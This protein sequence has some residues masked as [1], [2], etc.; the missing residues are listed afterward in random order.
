MISNK[1]DQVAVTLISFC[2]LNSPFKPFT[3]FPLSFVLHALERGGGG[4]VEN[5]T[6][7][8]Q[9]GS[10][11]RSKPLPFYILFLMEKVP[12][13]HTLHRKWYPFHLTS[14]LGIRFLSALVCPP[15]PGGGRGTQESF[16]RGGS[17]LRSKPLPSYKPILIE[18]LGTPFLYLPQKMVPLSYTYGATFT[19]SLRHIKACFVA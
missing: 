19:R 17:A 1:V 13:S 14:P 11:S 3:S 8:I 6:K 10:T 2:G 9:G 5:S 7:F 12:L 16:I 18:K 15:Y 4:G